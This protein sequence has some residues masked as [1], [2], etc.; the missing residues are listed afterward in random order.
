MF[1]EIIL[2]SLFDLSL[3]YQWYISSDHLNQSKVVIC[4]NRSKFYFFKQ[5]G[6]RVCLIKQDQKY[7]INQMIVFCSNVLMWT[8]TEFDVYIE[9]KS[10]IEPVFK[11]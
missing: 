4:L 3:I 2:D 11:H 10:E 6:V 9:K 7:S 5:F 1:S 8:K